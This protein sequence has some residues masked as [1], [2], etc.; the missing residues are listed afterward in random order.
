MLSLCK[1]LQGYVEVCSQAFR[2]CGCFGQLALP[3][4]QRGGGLLS[5]DSELGRLGLRRLKLGL[6]PREGLGGARY[7]L[8][9]PRCQDVF[10]KELQA[11]WLPKL[12]LK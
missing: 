7:R 2:L 4:G 6:A 5:C 12:N 10:M 8:L 9:Q 3:P 1:S 11:V